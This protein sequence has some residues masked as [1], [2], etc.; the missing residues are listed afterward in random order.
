MTAERGRDVHRA[1]RGTRLL[2][3][4]AAMALLAGLTACAS[5][6]AT[7]A[8][9]SSSP[10]AFAVS[11]GRTVTLPRSSSAGSG[12]VAS[13]ASE[14]A[15]AGRSHGRHH[16]GDRRLHDRARLDHFADLQRR[17]SRRAGRLQ[18]HLRGVQGDR[19]RA[20]GQPADGVHDDGL[21]P[22]ADGPGHLAHGVP[23]VVAD[24]ELRRRH[25][26]ADQWHRHHGADSGARPARP[27]SRAPAGRWS[28]LISNTSS[29]NTVSAVDPSAI[30][31]LRFADGQVAV[32]ASCNSGSG[33]AEITDST[34]IFGPIAMT[35]R[36][37][38]G[39][40]EDVEQAVTTVLQGTTTY[41]LSNDPAG[42]LLTIMSADGASG[43]QMTADP[44]LGADA[45]GSGS[46]AASSTA[47]PTS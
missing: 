32:N 20:V 5:N 15:V 35:M 17:P 9:G 36:A 21:R 29:A 46:A 8:A 22:G 30:A 6:S 7:P 26:D 45:F 43:L 24:L 25:P 39:P 12:R 23:V 19:R 34:I 33:S 2:A 10:A 40:T 42:A 41:T 3:G 37:C 27:R 31:W 44:T 16:R 1:I 4:L 11:V 14:G 18:Q 28:G 38:I 47:V 13:S